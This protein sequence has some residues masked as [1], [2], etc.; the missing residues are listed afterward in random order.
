[1]KLLDNSLLK[2]LFVEVLNWKAIY[3]VSIKYIFLSSNIYK[4]H[5]FNQPKSYEN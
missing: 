3:I 1:M 2:S 4:K 5:Y